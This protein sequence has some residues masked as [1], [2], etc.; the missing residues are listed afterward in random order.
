MTGWILCEEKGKPRDLQIG[1][2]AAPSSGATRID[3]RRPLGSDSSAPLR[4]VGPRNDD[5][6]FFWGGGRKEEEM[7]N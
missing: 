4:N 2:T 6:I 7:G 3:L 5:M 1:L